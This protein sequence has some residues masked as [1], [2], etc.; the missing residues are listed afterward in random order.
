MLVAPVCAVGQ[1][2]ILRDTVMG[3]LNAALPAG[4]QRTVYL[5]DDL[6]G[7]R[8][9]V[10]AVWGGAG[11]PTA[12]CMVQCACAGKLNEADHTRTYTHYQAAVLLRVEMSETVACLF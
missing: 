11:V 12:A 1:V 5:C 3:A 10:G 6:P 9:A 2:D 7:D 4:T 8:E